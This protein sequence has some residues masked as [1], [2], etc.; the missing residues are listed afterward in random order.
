MQI[1]NP[2]KA[3][4]CDQCDSRYSQYAGLYMHYKQVHHQKMKKENV[5]MFK[6]EDEP[7]VFRPMKEES[8][9]LTLKNILEFNKT[10]PIPEQQQESIGMMNQRENSNTLNNLHSTLQNSSSGFLPNL[11]LQKTE[12]EISSNNESNS[13]QPQQQPQLQEQQLQQQQSNTASIAGLPASV[14]SILNALDP[15]NMQS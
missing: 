5:R 8:G 13:E 3:Y 7:G 11:S 6:K 9:A 1:H 10:S 4:G 14:T 15:N 2:H 12:N